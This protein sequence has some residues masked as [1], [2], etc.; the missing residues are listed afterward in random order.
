MGIDPLGFRGFNLDK[1][2]PRSYSF[3]SLRLE[4]GFGLED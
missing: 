3:M 1:M 2:N 4:G